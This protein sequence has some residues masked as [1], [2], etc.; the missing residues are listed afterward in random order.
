M[1]LVTVKIM[2]NPSTVIPRTVYDFELPI[3]QHMHD[4]ANVAEVERKAVPKGEE[5][6]LED[7]YTA[8]TAKYDTSDGNRAIAEIYPRFDVFRRMVGRKN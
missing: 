4:E 3:L 2:R 7:A 8:L 1:E 6:S 5:P